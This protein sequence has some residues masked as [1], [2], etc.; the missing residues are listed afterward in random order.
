VVDTLP[1]SL[2]GSVTKFKG[3]GRRLGYP[4]ANLITETDLQDGV[5][6]GF[7][8]LKNWKHQP[9]LIFI[10]TPITMGEISRRVEA[11]LLDISDEDYYNLPLRLIV[12]YFHRSNQKFENMDELIKAMKADEAAGRQWFAEQ[13]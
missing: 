1:V 12:S 2:A 8:D 9:A 13:V 5:Y 10:G 11:Y 7:A 6:F 3:D 4:T